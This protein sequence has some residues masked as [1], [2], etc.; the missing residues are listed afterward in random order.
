M[1]GFD[2]TGLL[3]NPDELVGALG[4]P[5]AFEELDLFSLLA[6]ERGE[7]V[8]LGFERPGLPPA[9][10]SGGIDEAP[11]H[12]VE[13]FVVLSGLTRADIDGWGYQGVD[14]YAFSRTGPGQCLLSMRGPGTRVELAFATARVEGLR[15]YRSAPE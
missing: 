5:P 10:A 11:R 7:S 1:S 15:T 13:F 14:E 6:D 9:T 3:T 12:S 4:G 8:T 2:W